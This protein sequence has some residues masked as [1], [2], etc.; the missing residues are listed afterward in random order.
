MLEMLYTF[1][2]YFQMLLSCMVPDL[3]RLLILAHVTYAYN[4]VVL[5]I[6]Y[7]EYVYV[8]VRF[9]SIYVIITI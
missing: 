6:P 3:V 8:S 5:Y 9:A 7:L 2:C 1:R 4:I